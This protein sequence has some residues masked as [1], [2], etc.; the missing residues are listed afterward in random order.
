MEPIVQQALSQIYLMRHG[1]TEW[2]TSGQHTGRADVLLTAHGEQ[3]SRC[4]GEHVQAVSF[5]HVLV[6][7]LQRAIQ[8]CRAAGLNSK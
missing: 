8:T 6:S 3:E 7:P 5:Q 4:L 2:S 1:E